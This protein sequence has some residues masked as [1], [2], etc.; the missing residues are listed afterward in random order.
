MSQTQHP[1]HT[2]TPD[3]LK[4]AYAEGRQRDAKGFNGTVDMDST[5]AHILGLK[6]EVAFASI[7]DLAPDLSY[8]PDGGD[9]GHDFVVRWC[10]GERALNVKVSTFPSDPWLKVRASRID[11]STDA[12]VLGAIDDTGT[13][14]HFVGW[15]TPD[16][17]L[18]GE[19]TDKT[20]SENYI[21]EAEQLAPMPAPSEVTS[22]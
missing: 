5:D 20:G 14:V 19:R 21:L 3:D 9:D 1:T 8:N 7:Y 2:L 16:M 4:T 17:L 11:P 10:G 13:V 15:A 18:D 6:G 12:Y 22:V